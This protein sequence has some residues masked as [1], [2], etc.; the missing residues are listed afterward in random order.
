[1]TDDV[2]VEVA[3]SIGWVRLN[4]PRRANSVTPATI[5]Q[6]RGA[7]TELADDGRARSIVLTG[8]GTVFCSGA[9][10]QEMY[11]VQIAD[12]PDGLMSYLSEVWMPA[13]QDLV[14]AIW[15]SSKPIVA[16]FNGTATAG[17]LDFG[18]ACDARVAAEGARFG[19]SYINLGLVPVAGG[20]FLLPAVIG[21]SAAAELLAS[22]R[23]IDSREAREL[24]LVNS[25]FPAEALE[26][27]AAELA[28]SM[29]RGPAASVAHIKHISRA[30]LSDSFEAALR[31]SYEANTDLISRSDV[32]AK[33]LEVMQRYTGDRR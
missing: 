26:A 19:E 32:R 3:D 23:L 33:I 24:R 12:G 6:L 9:D 2:L 21:Q 31:A 15:Y 11:Q 13:V 28:A 7:I 20:A 4:R 30:A 1:M 25:V 10:V 29:G 16:A 27:A 18:L 17:G 5:E 14:R 8:V 22:A